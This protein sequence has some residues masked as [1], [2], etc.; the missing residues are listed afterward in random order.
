MRMIF[1]RPRP[2]CVFLD[3]PDYSH[4][5]VCSASRIWFVTIISLWHCCPQRSTLWFRYCSSETGPPGNS[6][7]IFVPFNK[8]FFFLK[9]KSTRESKRRIKQS[10]A[11]SSGQVLG[12]LE[13]CP[14][15]RLWVWSLAMFNPQGTY[16]RQ[17]TDVSLSHQCLSLSLPPP[18]SISLGED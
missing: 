7:S 14:M 13:C 18:W 16:G 10:K 5:P 4:E 15:H 6:M 8:F 2:L 12:W 11:N 17:P 1:P 9:K 3:F